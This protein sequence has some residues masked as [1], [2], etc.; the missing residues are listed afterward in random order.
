MYAEGVGLVK[1]FKALVT[2]ERGGTL[3]TRS[4]VRVRSF[5]SFSL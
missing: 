4:D 5:L 2:L 1:V 3:H